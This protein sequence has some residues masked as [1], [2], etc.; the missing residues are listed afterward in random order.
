MIKCV[1]GE[2]LGVEEHD[3]ELEVAWHW[4]K[5]MQQQGCGLRDERVFVLNTFTHSC[6]S[7]LTLF[8]YL[9]SFS[10]LQTSSI[11]F[12]QRYYSMLSFSLSHTGYPSFFPLAIY[13]TTVLY[14]LFL[15]MHQS[16]VLNNSASEINPLFLSLDLF[17][18]HQSMSAHVPLLF[19]PLII[20]PKSVMSAAQL[21]LIQ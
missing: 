20:N 16:N 3:A 5:K 9:I 2:V 21:R 8:S 19:S 15:L 13:S 17:S 18:T 4:D 11:S 1:V 14:L 7:L 6:L 12:F 10:S